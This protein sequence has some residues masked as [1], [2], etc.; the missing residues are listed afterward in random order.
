MPAVAVL[1]RFPC[2][3]LV[4]VRRTAILRHAPDFV[5][6]RW[7][8]ALRCGTRFL[9]RRSA[10]SGAVRFG[11]ERGLVFDASLQQ[12][13]EFCLA[14][15]ICVFGHGWLGRGALDIPLKE[16]HHLSLGIRRHRPRLGRNLS[17]MFNAIFR[18]DEQRVDR[19][20][21][22]WIQRGMRVTDPLLHRIG[23]RVTR[24]RRKRVLEAGQSLGLSLNSV[25]ERAFWRFLSIEW[26]TGDVHI[27]PPDWS[28][29]L[30][31]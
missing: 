2:N 5:G 30:T 17:W 14:I 26:V 10:S 19:W 8:R 3:I 6:L 15:C 9:S 16:V 29:E 21:I 13:Q 11:R 22:Q 18:S 7:S 28:E 31:A 24:R 27:V 25:R 12:I 1:S 23:C 20:S 4:H